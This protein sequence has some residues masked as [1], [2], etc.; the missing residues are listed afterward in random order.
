MSLTHAVGWGSPSSLLAPSTSTA[1]NADGRKGHPAKARL[2]WGTLD[3][4]LTPLSRDP[5]SPQLSPTHTKGPTRP[6]SPGP[7]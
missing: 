1:G 4:G 2:L 7:H 3:P 6:L 5:L